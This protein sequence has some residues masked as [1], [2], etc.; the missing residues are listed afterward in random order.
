MSD[1]CKRIVQLQKFLYLVRAFGKIATETIV[2]F[3]IK[4]TKRSVYFAHRWP[5][6][7]VS[8]LCKQVKGIF[9]CTFYGSGLNYLNQCIFFRIHNLKFTKT[10]RLSEQ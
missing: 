8:I 9:E 2:V 7:L 1:F 5:S 10:N 3:P 4:T 6:I